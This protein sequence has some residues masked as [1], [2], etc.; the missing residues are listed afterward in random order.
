M[1]HSGHIDV[2]EVYRDLER[3]VLFISTTLQIAFGAKPE[4]S[5]SFRQSMLR[6]MATV[7][8]NQFE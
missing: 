2:Q 5:L 1:D 7:H 3:T 8:N 6:A 4:A